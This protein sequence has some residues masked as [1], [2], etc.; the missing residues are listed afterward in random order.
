MFFCNLFFFFSS[1][2]DINFTLLKRENIERSSYLFLT[3]FV[4][5]SFSISSNGMQYIYNSSYT[6]CIG[7]LWREKVKKSY[8]IRESFHFNGMLTFTKIF[9]NNIYM[10]AYYKY[11]DNI[12][13]LQ[14]KVL[15]VIYFFSSIRLLFSLY[16][17]Q[18][19]LVQRIKSN[20]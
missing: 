13:Y 1:P 20:I 16:Y 14:Q 3:N 19:K 12:L 8:I 7:K 4:H 17:L 6:M 18:Y 5:Q 15:L 10:Y 9:C 2:S 11:I